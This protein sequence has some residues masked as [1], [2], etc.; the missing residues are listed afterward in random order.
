ML[1][2]F[3][4]TVGE[5][6]NNVNRKETPS[7]QSEQLDIARYIKIIRTRMNKFMFMQLMQIYT[8]NLIDSLIPNFCASF[9]EL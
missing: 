2:I 5:R 4:P 9:A 7:Y 6:I 3:L 1:P 8:Y